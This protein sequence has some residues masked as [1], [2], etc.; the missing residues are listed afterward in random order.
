MT[1]V[2]KLQLLIF[3]LEKEENSH[4]RFSLKPR[5]PCRILSCNSFMHFM[6]VINLSDSKVPRETVAPL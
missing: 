4:Y 6:N 5:K 1:L 3:F 2:E